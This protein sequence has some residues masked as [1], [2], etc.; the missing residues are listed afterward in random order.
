MITNQTVDP[1]VSS[2]K[3]H[4]ELDEYRAFEHEYR[5]RGWILVEAEFPRLI[6]LLAAPQLKPPAIVTGVKFDYTNYDLVAPSVQLVDP[7]TYEPYRLKDIPTT[8]QRTVE[9][10]GFAIQGFPV[11]F[12]AQ[13]RFLAQQ[14]LMQGYGPDDIP[15]L[16][17]AGVREYHDHPGHSGDSWELHRKSGAGRFVRLLEVISKYGIEPISNYRISLVPQTTG[18]VQ[19]EAPD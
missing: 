15:F 4:R 3:F 19:G 17:I 2:T 16:C 7:F 6:V 10:P 8:L 18:F 11:P 9:A 5:R 13:S 12:G 1:A 14:S